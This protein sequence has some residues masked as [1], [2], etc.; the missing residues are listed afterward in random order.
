MPGTELRLEP[1][2]RS[3][4]YGLDVFFSVTDVGWARARSAMM[5]SSTGWVEAWAAWARS[6]CVERGGHHWWLD[7]VRWPD[8]YEISVYCSACPA[9]V[10]DLH[11][12]GLCMLY[13]EIPMPFGGVMS[14]DAGEVSGRYIPEWH[15]PVQAHLE[16]EHYPGGPWDGDEW[17]VRIIVEPGELNFAR[18]V[19]PENAPLGV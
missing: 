6:S 2:K 4:A 19:E 17:D 18:R 12:D 3:A 8:D 14:I 11:P 15:G 1:G 16:V 10:D 9:G 7:V 5:S 13:G